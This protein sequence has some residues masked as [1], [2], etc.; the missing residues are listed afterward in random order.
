MAAVPIDRK[1]VT[2][3]L[4]SGNFEP[5]SRPFVE[6]KPQ[7][8]GWFPALGGDSASIGGPLFLPF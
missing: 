3:Y 7:A 5:L 8:V 1:P 2:R 6:D 4:E